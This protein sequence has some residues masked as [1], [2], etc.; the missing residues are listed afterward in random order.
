MSFLEILFFINIFIASSKFKIN[1]FVTEEGPMT[2][3][4]SPFTS[5]S[6]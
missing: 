5:D 3:V 4:I 6:K 2:I 1:F